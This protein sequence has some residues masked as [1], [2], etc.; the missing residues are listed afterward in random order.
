MKSSSIG[1]VEGA[2]SSR[3]DCVT[4]RERDDQDCGLR[5]RRTS[6]NGQKR[7]GALLVEFA[8]LI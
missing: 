5:R 8:S 2:D 7:R 4:L 1:L 6:R 3:R